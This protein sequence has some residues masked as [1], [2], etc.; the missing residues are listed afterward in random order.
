M[1]GRLLPSP[2]VH[3]DTHCLQTSP[4]PSD[5]YCHC[6]AAAA[7]LVALPL[8]LLPRHCYLPCHVAAA[9]FLAAQPPLP[10]LPRGC[11]CLPHRAAAAAFLPSSLCGRQPLLNRNAPSL[12]LPAPPT[13]PP[14]QSSLAANTVAALPPP[15]C[16]CITAA[17]NALHRRAACRRCA[18]AHRPCAADAQPLPPPRCCR[19]QRCTATK[20]PPLP[21]SLTFQLSLPSPF[22]S[23]LPLPLLVDC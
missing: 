11:R 7:F 10:S 18:A 2:L 20:L 9:A 5:L 17:A 23:P 12:P 16:H 6:C 22:L 15:H 14:T 1:V 21:P 8:P 13:R 19:R 4:A 3:A